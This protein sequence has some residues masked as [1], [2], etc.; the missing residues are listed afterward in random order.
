MKKRKIT[1]QEQRTAADILT[2]LAFCKTVEEYAKEW[3]EIYK[4]YGLNA[5]PFTGLPVSDKDYEKNSLE[6]ERQTMENRF[7]Y[8]ED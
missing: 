8:Y 7:G 1:H 5:D 6:Y 3:N 2:R 4:V